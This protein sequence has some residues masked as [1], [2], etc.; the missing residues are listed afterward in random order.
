MSLLELKLAADFCHYQVWIT[1]QRG[2]LSLNKRFLRDITRFVVCMDT[3]KVIISRI[4]RLI[5]KLHDG[6]GFAKPL[7]P[8]NPL[9]EYFSENELWRVSI[10]T[11]CLLIALGLFIYMIAHEDACCKLLFLINASKNSNS[12]EKELS[13]SDNLKG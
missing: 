7:S 5:I 4:L 9:P 6:G 3:T 10:V 2:C 1:I 8:T 13:S 12:L 11:V